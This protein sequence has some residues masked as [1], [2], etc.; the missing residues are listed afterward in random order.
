MD[1]ECHF[2]VARMIHN[3]TMIIYIYITSIIMTYNFEWIRK[4][5]QVG[6][7][8]KIVGGKN[9]NEKWE[10]KRGKKNKLWYMINSRYLGGKR[11]H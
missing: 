9:S 6:W 2:G 1:K 10:A 4:S 8:Y 11:L 3:S 5:S 7:Y